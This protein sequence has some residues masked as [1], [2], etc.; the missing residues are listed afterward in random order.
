MTPVTP[1]GW[2]MRIPEPI[3]MPIFMIHAFPAEGNRQPGK[4]ERTFSL[5]LRVRRQIAVSKRKFFFKKS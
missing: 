2:M 1:A 5:A 4:H 3:Y